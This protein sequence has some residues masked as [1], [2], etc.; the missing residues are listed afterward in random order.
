VQNTFNIVGV[1]CGRFRPFKI[2][3]PRSIWT[4]NI[5]IIYNTDYRSTKKVSSKRE[6]NKKMKK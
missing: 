4:N 3:I 2:N 6:T 1:S 5:G